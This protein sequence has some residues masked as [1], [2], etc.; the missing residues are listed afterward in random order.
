MIF[1]E[2]NN[3]ILGKLYPFLIITF[4]KFIRNN[5]SSVVQD[6]KLNNENYI[7]Q[8]KNLDI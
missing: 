1:S 8:T 2:K 5:S 3:E 4:L 7:K 6:L